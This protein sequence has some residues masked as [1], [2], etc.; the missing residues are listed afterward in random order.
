MDWLALL[1]LASSVSRKE[2]IQS[3]YVQ[4]FSR[5]KSLW[6][7]PIE[8]FM[9]TLIDWTFSDDTNQFCI[10]QLQLARIVCD[11]LDWVN[12]FFCGQSWHH[13]TCV[14]LRSIFTVRPARPTSCFSSFIERVDL[15]QSLP[16]NWFVS[17][18]GAWTPS[19]S[20][21][22]KSSATRL[23]A[24]KE[25]YRVVPIEAFLTTL[26]DW[27][28][29]VRRTKFAS[30]NLLELFV[31]TLMD[32]IFVGWQSWRNSWFLLLGALLCIWGFA[33]CP[34]RTQQRFAA[35]SL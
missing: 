18:Q 7:G 14:V 34:P 15:I 5:Q 8:S 28:S 32:W 24:S 22:S 25:V 6:L 19:P 13:W 2:H 20:N 30:F 16:V 17:W 10:M 9:A 12:L 23:G 29:S 26:I 35:A 3:T 31:T 27:T 1:G 21:R 33:L 4:V 11:N